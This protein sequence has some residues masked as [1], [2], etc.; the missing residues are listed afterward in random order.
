M[1][2]ALNIIR[3]GKICCLTGFHSLG[4]M[5]LTDIYLDIN[6]ILLKNIAIVI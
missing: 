5:T 4:F 2:F 6:Y 1:L 3:F